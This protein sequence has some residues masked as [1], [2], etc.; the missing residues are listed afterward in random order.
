MILSWLQA[1]IRAF[2]A[3]KRYIK[4][5]EQRIALIVVQRNLRKYLKLRNW[6]WYRLWQRVRPLLNVTRV[7][8]E[9]R[10]LEEKANKAQENFEREEKM[11]LAATLD[12]T[13]GNVSDFLDKQAKLQTQKADLEAQLNEALDRLNTEEEARNTLFQGKK[14]TDQEIGGLKKDLEDLELAMQKSEQDKSTKDHQI[15]NLNDEIAHQDELINKINKEKKHLQECNQKT[16]ED[17]QN[18]EDKCN[19]LNKVKAKLEQTLDELEDSNEREKKLRGEVEK[20]KRKV[21][22]DLKLT[23]E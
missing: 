3:R 7:E 23:Q 12:S 18:I 11:N 22:G 15:R 21:E 10:A 14:K 2:N 19:H 5:Q 4:L 17:L 16:A 6:G 20:N 1:F 9:M 8:D 13:K